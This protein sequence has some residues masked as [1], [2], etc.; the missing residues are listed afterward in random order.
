MTTFSFNSDGIRI[1]ALRT[2]SS[3]QVILDVGEYQK[4]FLPFFNQGDCNM[5]VTIEFEDEGGRSSQEEVFEVKP[6]EDTTSGINAPQIE[7]KEPFFPKVP[8][9]DVRPMQ[10]EFWGKRKAYCERENMTKQEF[11]SMLVAD[12]MLEN[13]DQKTKDLSDSDL[14]SI[15]NFY[16][17]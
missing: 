7:D 13:M 6:I 2:D 9:S 11:K 16:V 8:G 14:Q 17:L 1:K 4:M 15:M 10:I 5:K 3:F 12:G